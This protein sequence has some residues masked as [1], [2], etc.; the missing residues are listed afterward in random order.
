MRQ[1]VIAVDDQPDNLLIIEDYLGKSYDVITFNLGQAMIDYFE[2]GHKA[3]LVLLDIVM[4][5]PDGYALCNWLKSNPI[6]RDIPVIFLTGLESTDEEA[7]ALSIGAEDFLHK[8]LSPPVLGARVRNHLLLSQARHALQNQ[9]R[10]LEKLVIE[11][12]RKIQEQSDELVRRTEQLISAQSAIISAFCALV[13]A[14]DNETGNHVRRTQH[15]LLALC[16]QL[17]RHPRF[18]AELTQTN[19]QLMFKSAPL[20]DIGKVAI[21][22]HILLKPGKLTPDERLIMQRHAEFGAEAIAAA[23]R[24]IG[25]GSASFLGYARQ[26]ALTHHER[27]DGCGY[28]RK[29]AGDAIP[30]AGRLMAVAYVYDALISRRSYKPAFPHAE[31]VDIM[32]AERGRHFDPD[33]LDCMLDCAEQ[34][35]DIARCFA[36]PP[37][38]T[39]E[40][41]T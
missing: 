9:N 16:E 35:E 25:E 27:W 26:I 24:E 38:D 11:R 20:H 30:L 36:D 34:F 13:E 31:A 5:M 14:R 8:P 23:E 33:I 4:P 19:I 6:T 22:D 1:K 18:A 21:P 15:Y 3:D 39:T 10:G 17:V 28:P 2:S 29:L 12:T 41:T 32:R 37:A 7:Y 40:S